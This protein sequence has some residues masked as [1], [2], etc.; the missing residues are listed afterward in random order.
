MPIDL[1][2][3]SGNL[4]SLNRRIQEAAARRCRDADSVRL[5][6]VTKTVGPA[7]VR[8][9]YELGVRHFGENRLE[10][11]TPKADALA[12]PGVCWHMIGRIQR[13][14][15]RGVVAVFDRVDSVD[16]IPLVDELEQ[17]CAEMGRILP[18]LVEANVSGEASKAGFNL[19]ELPAVLGHIGGRPHIRVEGLMT[20]APFVAAP[21]QVRPIFAR[22]RALC[23]LHRLPVCSMGMSNDFE[24][25]VEEGATEVRIGSELF[26]SG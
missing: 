6:A 13:R 10:A 9:L 21:E 20:M 25:A 23:D 15:A 1:Q 26:R 14:K 8:A 4:A 5:V 18:V 17:R 7:E 2:R 19:S 22:L 12:L 11:A 3:L 16:R 24:V